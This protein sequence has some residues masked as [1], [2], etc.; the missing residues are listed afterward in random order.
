MSNILL[1]NGDGVTVLDS[2]NTKAVPIDGEGRGIVNTY[3]DI[4]N[5][6][7]PYLYMRVIVRNDSQDGTH[8]KGE[9]IITSL[10]NIGKVDVNG[11]KS[12]KE[13]VAESDP[14]VPAHVKAITQQNITDWN[15]KSNFS[16]NYNDLTNKPIIPNVSNKVDK[17][18]TSGLLKNDGTVDTETQ[19]KAANAIEM[20]DGATEEKVLG[21]ENGAVSWVPKPSNGQ[22]GL[23]AFEL[24]KQNGYQ[25]DDVSAW[26]ASLKANIG[27]FK[28]VNYDS[29][30]ES[31]FTSGGIGTSYT[32]T[33]D[34]LTAGTDT[35]KTVVLL[36]NNDATMPTKTMMIVTEDDG[37]GGYQFVYAGNLNN[38]IPSNTLTENDIDSTQLSN[39]APNALAKATDVKELKDKFSETTQVTDYTQANGYIAGESSETSGGVAY[40]AGDVVSS[41]TYKYATFNVESASKIWFIGVLLRSS[42][43]SKAGY[44]FYDDNDNVIEAHKFDKDT[45]ASETVLKEYLLEVPANAKNFKTVVWMAQTPLDTSVFYFYKYYDVEYVKTR[46]FNYVK[47]DVLHTDKTIEIASIVAGKYINSNPGIS[48]STLGSNTPSIAFYYIKDKKN[49]KVHVPRVGNSYSRNYAYS[50]DLIESGSLYMP[51]ELVTGTANEQTYIVE[52]T[53][54]YNYLVL[55]YVPNAGNPTVREPNAIEE[56]DNK[57]DSYSETDQR[58]IDSM[59]ANK[60]SDVYDKVRPLKVLFIGNSFAT[61]TAEKL[62]QVFAALGYDITIGVSYI[63]GGR[64][65]QYDDLKNSSDTTKYVKYKGGK[66]IYISTNTSKLAAYNSTQR[67]S[68]GDTCNYNGKG[69]RCIEAITVPE[70]FNVNHWEICTASTTLIDKLNDENWDVVF[71]IQGSAYAGLYSSYEPYF[72]SLLKWL[73]K[74][75]QS[76]GYKVGWFMPWAWSTARIEDPSIGDG[77]TNH[78]GGATNA[79]MYANICSATESN[80]NAHTNE[81]TFF[82]PCGT[83]V[84]NQ[85]NYYDNVWSDGQHLNNNGYYAAALTLFGVLAP[86]FYKYNLEDLEWQDGIGMGQ[87][88]FANA[89]VSALNALTSPFEMTEISE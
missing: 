8:L 20:P 79:E 7:N 78:D 4:A 86:Y 50:N 48:T 40:S 29:S 15:N 72:T 63:G 6:R 32:G 53:A 88:S 80:I 25:G 14:N 56:L 11:I 55:T 9:Y 85:L 60:K 57:F 41:T 73:P 58:I 26:L 87:N 28:F 89:K 2:T 27:A 5:I 17:S 46:D 64:L 69:Y 83:A 76:L 19:T 52:N 37:N 49:L 74:K 39:P 66:W 67:Y 77:T 22:D 65:S 10:T 33:I 34:S 82:A 75:I 13:Y 51:E 68:I 38:A 44:A 3:E 81:I 31:T 12:F 42:S 61:Y 62:P 54:N 21:Y 43:N 16:G 36:M 59:A 30:A 71:F 47:D 84:E 35:D 18:S 70:V 23:S 45:T 1:N 24:A